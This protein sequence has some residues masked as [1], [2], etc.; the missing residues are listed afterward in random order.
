MLDRLGEVAGTRVFADVALLFSWEAW[1]ASDAENRPSSAIDYLD[2]V[3]ALHRALR[4]SGAAVDI[5]RPGADL[6]GYRL[7]VVPGLHLIRD[8][9]AKTLDAAVTGGA[10]TLVTFYSGIV[11]E[12]D[13]V[14]PGGYPAVWRNLL[15]IRV[16]EFAPSCRAIR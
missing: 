2:Q 16:E 3:W 4:Q 10:H 5:V 13:R 14:R 15:G 9:D 8:R 7:V 11:D 12:N 1:W 6:S